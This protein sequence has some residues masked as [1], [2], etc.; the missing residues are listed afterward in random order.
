MTTDPI[1][2]PP[3]SDY[4]DAALDAEPVL[5]HRTKHRLGW[6][7]V[8]VLVLIL[9]SVLPPLLN[10]NR[11]QHRVAQA[12]SASIGRPVHFDDI[13]LHLLPLP[14]L[15]IQ[16][17]VVEED[18]AFGAE[19]ALR[20]STVEA[21]LR[22][23]SLWRRRVEVS[24]IT[25]QAPS[26][27][28]VRRPD[29][30]W[31]LQGVV[32]NAGYLQNAPTSQGGAG[33]T[34]RFPYIEA[35]G[36]RINVKSGQDKLPWSL[37]DARLALWLPDQSEWRIR[38]RGRPVRT[39]TDVSDVGDLELE[40]SLG[41]GSTG[42]LDQPL[43]I[44]GKWSSTP[45]GEAAKLVLGRPTDARGAASAE[46][47][48]RGTPAHMHLST[49][50]HLHNVRRAEFVPTL[51]MSLDAHCEAEAAGIVHQLHTLRC[52]FPTAE[53]D[54]LFNNMFRAREPH[55]TTAPDI[56]LLQADLPDL[57]HPE[58]GT[59]TLDLESAR[60]AYFLDWFRIVS[61]RIPASVAAAGSVSLHA[62]WNAP[63]TPGAWSLQ[64]QCRCEFTPAYRAAPSAMGPAAEPGP[65]R[66]PDIWLLQATHTPTTAAPANVLAVSAARVPQAET[67]A[68]SALPER[69][70]APTELRGQISR[71]GVTLQYNSAALA[72]YVASLV[73]PLGDNL[74]AVLRTAPE[75]PVQSQRVWGEP[76]SW[77]AG[78][79]AAPSSRP[80]RRG[81]H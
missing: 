8:A 49:D 54:G 56:L 61:S 22:L 11:Y 25:L 9:L 51:P 35:T 45:L 19:P 68:P 52:G 47:E 63:A 75:T 67:A 48:L 28:L 30:R 24:H 3:P 26:I 18:P 71:S 69:V 81:R 74:P 27:N 60:P 1:N 73:P 57:L 10:V 64:S 79:S 80:R 72:G 17:F 12:I 78:S 44:S 15:T 65:N 55:V 16:N 36:A 40:G 31:N 70:N 66:T 41:R 62:D 43:A 39:D 77:T 38:L 14:G 29:G 37:L 20:A 4:T 5:S 23:A 46:L 42:V 33:A 53:A 32:T 7:L 2:T 76:Q 6:V 21:R 13:H 50:F 58:T 34:P 59:A